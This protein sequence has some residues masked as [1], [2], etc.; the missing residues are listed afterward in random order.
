MTTAAPT[1]ALDAAAADWRSWLSV[2]GFD[3][4]GAMTAHAVSDLLAGVPPHLVGAR[5]YCALTAQGTPDYVGQTRRPLAERIAEHVRNGN[6]HE[7]AWV[8][9]VSVCGFTPVEVD[10]HERSAHIWMVPLSRRRAR[11]MPAAR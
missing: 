7:W 3:D 2:R 5:I 9:S 6:G 8:V 11:K 1:G 10:S 4:D